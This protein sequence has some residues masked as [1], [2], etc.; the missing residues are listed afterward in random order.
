M[1]KRPL[2]IEI[3]TTRE[4]NLNHLNEI[5]SDSYQRL[6]ISI[7]P[8]QMMYKSAGDV[9]VWIKFIADFSVWQGLIAA[10]G[11]GIVGTLSSLIATDLYKLSKK[12]YKAKTSTDS[13]AKV[14]LSIPYPSERNSCL[15]EITSGSEEEIAKQI[16]KFGEFSLM[17]Q[18]KLKELDIESRDLASPIIIEITNNE[19]MK[20]TWSEFP[21]LQ[22]FEETIKL[23]SA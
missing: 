12:I 16:E 17:L 10:G 3:Q 13:K 14:L 2:S 4:F 7:S 23:N 6:E 19:Q 20:F 15:L 1:E 9:P 18:A 21:K 8:S 11:A 22:R 5:F